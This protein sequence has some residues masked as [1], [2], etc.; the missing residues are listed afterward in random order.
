MLWTV[1]V[2]AALTSACGLGLAT[3]TGGLVPRPWGAVAHALA[4]G[5]LVAVGGFAGFEK[6]MKVLI[7]TMFFAILACAA[8]TFRDP[9]P[10]SRGLF[11]PTIPGGG[12]TSLLSVLGGIGG[13]IAML[14][15]NYWLREE[16]MAGPGWLRLRARATSPSPT[17]SRRSSAWRS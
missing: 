16:Q 2:S 3:L 12:G 9:A 13:S 11:V 7:G 14:A 15:Y 17:S 10:S 1:S 4:G 6:V 5:A 8:L